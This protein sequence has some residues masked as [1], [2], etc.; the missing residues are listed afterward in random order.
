MAHSLVKYFNVPVAVMLLAS[1]GSGYAADSGERV[2]SPS[3]AP[4]ASNGN[5]VGE[6]SIYKQGNVAPFA[7]YLGSPTN[8]HD[9]VPADGTLSQGVIKVEPG[10]VNAPG[11]GKKVSWTTTGQLYAQSKSTEDR[12]D[13]LDADAALVFDLVV[14]EPPQ[15]AVIVR[16]DCKY[17]CIGLVD[18]TNTIKSLPVGQKS[19]LKIPLSCFAATGADFGNVNTPFLIYTTSRFVASFANIRWTPGVAKDADVMNC[20]KGKS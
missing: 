7:L 11:D 17:P 6:L 13:Y 12:L 19:T 20:K 1:A 8:W 15:S 4:A 18:A 14:H 3:T 9:P 16:V 10:E 2:S 5:A